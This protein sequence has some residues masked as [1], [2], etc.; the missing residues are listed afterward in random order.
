MKPLRFAV[1]GI[2]GY[3]SVH[4]RAIEWLEELGLTKLTSVIALEDERKNKPDFVKF[5][6]DKNITLY[7]TIDHF[8]EEGTNSAD[9]LT[10]PIG[11]HQHVPVSI[12]ALRKGLDVYCEKPIAAKVQEVDNLILEKEKTARKIVIGFQHI[13]SN[14]IQQLK[15]R[16]CDGRLGKVEYISAVCGW[17]R[18]MQYYER[19]DWAGKLSLKG[20]WILDTPANNAH[21]HY[22]MNMLYLSSSDPQ[23]SAIPVELK[24][25]LYRANFIASSDL[26]QMKFK[27]DYDTKCFLIFAHCNCKELGP[28]MKIRCENGEVTWQSENGTTIIHYNN[29]KIER[30]D[31]L[32]RKNWRYDGFKDIVDSIRK[33]TEPLC[34]PQL[35]RTHTVAINAM[36]K[37]CPEIIQINDKYIVEI[38]DDEMFPPET[39]GNF[40]KVANLDEY[41]I[42][43]CDKDVFF[44]NL[45]IPWTKNVR[46]KLINTQE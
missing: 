43:A 31:N 20:R 22:L 34:T 26:L 2:G 29:R 3:S 40:R 10:V 4:I 13:Y 41:I 1:I 11:I 37:S 7:K 38:E 44:S 23:K 18:S 25:E 45:N 30:F 19:N 27:T 5:L 46:S 21:A 35:A 8:F 42:E 24:A 33:N 9:V 28:I 14:S 36:H 39:K 12:L 15:K 16:I 32:I 6:L 17:P